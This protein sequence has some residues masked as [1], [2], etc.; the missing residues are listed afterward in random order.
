MR[1]HAASV[2]EDRQGSFYLQR[3][4]PLCS[5]D[6]LVELLSRLV[7]YAPHLAANRYASHIL[8]DLLLRIHNARAEAT[9]ETRDRLEKVVLALHDAFLP[10]YLDFMHDWVASHVLR[11]CLCALVGAKPQAAK[12]RGKNSKHKQAKEG[13]AEEEEDRGCG[14]IPPQVHAG[15]DLRA[16][17]AAITDELRQMPRREAQALVVH[18]HS[19]AVVCVILQ[20]AAGVAGKEA[21]PG[22]GLG[23]DLVRFLLEWATTEGGPSNL[24]LIFYG[25]A[26]EVESS[27][28]LQCVLECA[29]AEDFGA[30]CRGCM[31]G[32]LAEYAQHPISN[33]VLQ[34]ALRT[35]ARVG[36]PRLAE[37]MIEELLPLKMPFVERFGGVVFHL[38]TLALAHSVLQEKLYAELVSLSTKAGQD[39]AELDFL[40]KMI[41]KRTADQTHPG[42]RSQSFKSIMNV[43]VLGLILGQYPLPMAEPLLRAALETDKGQSALRS[44][45]FTGASAKLVIEPMLSRRLDGTFVQDRF[46]DIVASEVVEMAT[47]PAAHLVLRKLC[48]A[49]P[50]DR[51]EEVRN[52]YSRQSD[53]GSDMGAPSVF[54]IVR[55]LSEKR[56]LLTNR[57]GRETVQ[58]LAVDEYSKSPE[59]WR[60]LRRKEKHKL[61]AIREIT[62]META[63]RHKTEATKARRRK[64][65]TGNIEGMG[66]SLG[67]TQE[68]RKREATDARVGAEAKTLPQDGV[69][70]ARKAKKRK[71]KDDAGPRSEHKSRKKKKR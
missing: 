23:A 31:L 15:E 48:R 29:S 53:E 39:G 52:A 49:L 34:S 3:L 25:M 8:E 56:R 54:Q 61:A 58:A 44:L 40:E 55:R 46:V 7:D 36:T 14:P 6:Q 43:R 62:E 64:A 1:Y 42:T 41:E 50:V 12:R 10:Q 19:C 51:E 69:K 21:Q 35:C 24:H 68:Q 9:G 59:S 66:A 17:F 5:A 2:A 65:E 71:P 13:P 20:L 57:F 45:M 16:A 67:H 63:K 70:Q 18:P 28:F 32:K 30:L 37:E 4:I 60:A 11:A 26:G 38:C 33:Y 22:F 27:H 47:N